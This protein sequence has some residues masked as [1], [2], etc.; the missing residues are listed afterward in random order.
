MPQFKLIVGVLGGLAAF[1]TSVYLLVNSM[2]KPDGSLS[3]SNSI[4]KKP[5]GNES[6]EKK[7]IRL[8]NQVR[9]LFDSNGNLLTPEVIKAIIKGQYELA[10]HDMKTMFFQSRT[11]RRLQIN[12]LAEFAKLVHKTQTDLDD[13][14]EKHLSAILS[15]FNIGKEEWTAA[16]QEWQDGNFE[17]ST[18]SHLIEVMEKKL[19][20]SY[21]T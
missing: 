7:F 20:D 5:K 2:K 15:W 16:E 14:N 6:Y 4:S 18:Y 9:A 19:A 12:N 3:L 1:G 8:R 17:G 11:Q 13:L 10:N 21:Q